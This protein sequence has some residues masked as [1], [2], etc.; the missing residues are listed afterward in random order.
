MIPRIR[1]LALPLLL[2]AGTAFAN[3]Y[4]GQPGGGYPGAHP[5]T[6]FGVPHGGMPQGAMRT[7]PPVQ[8]MQRSTPWQRQMPRSAPAPRPEPAPTLL[9]REGLGKLNAFLE[10]GVAQQPGAVNTY[11]VREIAPYFDLQYMSRWAAG[12]LYRQLNPAQRGALAKGLG[13]LFFK[14]MATHLA[15]YPGANIRYLPS[16]DPRGKEATVRVQVGGQAGGQAG[17]Q[18]RASVRL[19]FRM[20]KSDN[21]WKVFDVQANGRSAVVHYRQLLAKMSRQGGIQG[22]LQQLATS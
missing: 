7:M 12:P 17:G 5:G 6:Q 2:A 4:A 19:D 11:L 16:K 22:M 1:T 8:G 3:P 21:G 20:Y 14:N 10:S 13:Q 18:H 15:G 9:I